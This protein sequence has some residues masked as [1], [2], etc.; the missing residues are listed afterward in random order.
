MIKSR[1]EILG[2]FGRGMLCLGLG[3]AVLPSAAFGRGM[4]LDP[5]LDPVGGELDFGELEPL[6][7]L[8][9][10]TPPESLLPILV[11]KLRKGTDARTLMT[12]GALA[13]ARTFGGEDYNGYHAF[14]A[15]LPALEMGRRL[16]KG[17]QPLPA[18]KVLYRNAQFMQDSGGRSDEKL[19]T[20]AAS[21]GKHGDLDKRVRKALRGRDMAGAEQAFAA[22]RDCS[23][24]DAYDHL[25]S[26]VVHD[27]IDVHRTVL[28]WRVWDMLN[29]VG[30]QHA[31]T[32]MRTSL[33]H[34]VNVEQ[35]RVQRGRE[36]PEIR[37]LLPKLMR[38]CDLANKEAGTRSVADDHL[39]KIA[40][41]IACSSRADAAKTMA[42]CLNE[43]YAPAELAEALSIAANMLLL[44]D[45]GRTRAESGKPVGSV[46]GASVGVHACDAAVAWRSI[47]GVVNHENAMASLV[48]AAYHTGGQSHRVGDAPY[49]WSDWH[50]TLATLD[51]KRPEQLL[52][53]LG[54][55]VEEGDQKTSCAIVQAYSE[56][57]APARPVFDLLLKTAVSQ[58]GALHAEKYYDTVVQEFEQ[59]R[60]TFKWKHLIGLAR[61]SASE[62]GF[63]APGVAEAR[64]LLAT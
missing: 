55:C 30:K 1:R 48:V 9:Q 12:A 46:H 4:D 20:V 22:T 23:P 32:M 37:S 57:G 2:G 38:D 21:E 60:P 53:E 59:A 34:C 3:P 58:D 33:R 49:P 25:V 41:K 61:V 44:A 63:P 26:S 54:P 36:E 17:M 16:P 6:V 35:R 42:A 40:T 13:N 50:D 51:G 29:L 18:L 19:H 5:A 7:A 8:M 11:K 45:P 62:H 39:E 27:D 10:E 28:A 24:I 14:M 52:K 15:M 64:K 43:G 31:H 47:A 56:H